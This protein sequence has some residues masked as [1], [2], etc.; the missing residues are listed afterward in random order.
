M[1]LP[2]LIAQWSGKLPEGFV[3]PALSPEARPECVQPRCKQPVGLKKNGELAKSCPRCLERRARSCRRRRAALVAEGGCRRCAYRKRRAGD[4]LCARCREDRDIERAQK[5][6]DTIDA[7]AI[8]AF[9]ARPDRAHEPSNLDCGIS[10]WNARP[11]AEPTA[12]YWSPLP[13]PE[14]LEEQD[15]RW[16][17][18]NGKLHRRY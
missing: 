6:Q 9:A 13:D 18:M 17:P 2:T 16:S 12:A 15:W 11:T 7:A 10:P 3:R 5:R 1:D 14:P 8:D 4:F